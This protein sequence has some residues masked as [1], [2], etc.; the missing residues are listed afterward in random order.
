VSFVVGAGLTVGASFW[1][2]AGPAAAPAVAGVTCLG[3]RTVLATGAVRAGAEG[4][5]LRVDN[6]TGQAVELQAG[7]ANAYLPPGASDVVLPLAPGRHQV[8]CATDGAAA[9][10]D[11]VDDGHIYTRVALPCTAPVLHDHTRE[12]LIR[13]GD[14][15][16]LTANLLHADAA[17]VQIVGYP[18]A[19][20][21]TVAV[22]RDGQAVATATWHQLVSDRLWTLG[23][24]EDCAPE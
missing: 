12:S 5:Q 18:G 10:L 15:V 24:V 14:V 7:G 13:H 22:V 3:D 2:S 20:A 6:R 8:S 23:V 1:L 17:S 21:R 19:T 11:V 9:M 16:T 4:A